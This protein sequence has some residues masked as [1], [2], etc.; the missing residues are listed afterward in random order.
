[1]AL[2]KRSFNWVTSV[3]HNQISDAFIQGMLNRMI[4]GFHKY[5]DLKRKVDAPDSIKCLK[6]RLKNYSE[7]GNTEWLIDVANFAMMEFMRPRHKKAHFR[8]TGPRRRS[9]QLDGAWL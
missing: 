3:P 7:T 4:H 6:Q 1:M 2:T 9:A 8:P 5:S